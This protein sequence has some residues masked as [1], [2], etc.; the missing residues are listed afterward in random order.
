MYDPVQTTPAHLFDD[1]VSTA[2]SALDVV[3]STAES[4]RETVSGVPESGSGVVS[5]ASV[6]AS[7]LF[8]SLPV[9]PELLLLQ[10]EA[11][12]KEST[13]EKKRGERMTKIVSKRPLVPGKFAPACNVGRF[14]LLG[15]AIWYSRR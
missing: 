11:R 3:S 8:W 1:D 14:G 5:A 7:P 4:S 15:A 2:E 10:A 13:A 6:P 12:T 9:F